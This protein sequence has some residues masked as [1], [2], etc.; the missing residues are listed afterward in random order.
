MART[1]NVIHREGFWSHIAAP[2]PILLINEFRK[3]LIDYGCTPRLAFIAFMHAVAVGE[4][5]LAPKHTSKNLKSDT[6][7]V[8]DDDKVLLKDVSGKVINALPLSN[9]YIE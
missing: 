9:K 3:K 8:F 4:I 7:G 6:T 1:A 5:I 2:A